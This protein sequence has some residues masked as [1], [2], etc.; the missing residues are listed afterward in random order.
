[1]ITA[2]AQDAKCWGLIDANL[3]CPQ[4]RFIGTFFNLH[5]IDCAP[6]RACMS[7]IVGIIICTDGI[8]DGGSGSI[9]EN[10]WAH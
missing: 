5:L 2:S 10:N 9:T 8:K 4:I 3:P 6:S 1:M 7:C